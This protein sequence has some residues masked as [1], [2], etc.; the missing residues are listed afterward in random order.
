MF[1]KKKILSVVWILIL[2]STLLVFLWPRS[3]LGSVDE[4]I[5]SVSVEI[6]ENTLEHGLLT[7][8]K[9]RIPN[10]MKL[11]TC[12]SGTLTT[13]PQVQFPTAWRTLRISRTT[14]RD[15]GWT[16]TYIPNRIVMA[17]VIQSYLAAPANLFSIPGCIAW[18]IGV[19]RP[20]WILWV[21]FVEWSLRIDL[22]VFREIMKKQ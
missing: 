14:V 22:S 8:F 15:I 12:W 3:F 16:F 10:S 1:Q 7:C 11:W 6:I 13:Y 9:L 2:I 17:I 21:R 18:V 4:E 5:K 20:I 19:I